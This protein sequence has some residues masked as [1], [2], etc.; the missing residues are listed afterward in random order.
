MRKLFIPLTPEPVVE[1]K[2]TA[3]HYQFS[4]A[5]ETYEQLSFEEAI[6]R[7]AV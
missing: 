2:I 3:W 5:A 7:Q 6:Y 1:K 4:T